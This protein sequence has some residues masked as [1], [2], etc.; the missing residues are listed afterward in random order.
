M[1]PVTAADNHVIQALERMWSKIREQDS[2]IP[3]VIFDLTP[4]ASSSCVS[5]GWD[6][7]TPVVEVNLRPGG[8]NST[9]AELLEF[10]LHQAAHSIAGPVNPKSSEGR[11][12][13]TTYR[14]AAEAIGLVTV[15][16][17]TGYGAT[18]LA[19]GTRT[20]YRSEISA[21]GRALAK[22]EPT[23]QVKTGRSSRNGVVLVCSCGPEPRKIRIRGNPEKIDITGIRCE[24]CQSPFT[25]S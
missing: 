16:D 6:Q 21:L 24:I 25:P 3:A 13:G 8:R 10:L 23:E 18:S 14:V 19:A 22:W 17:A 2:R 15:R 4:G 1:R 12:H 5:V 11:W 7:P 20:R 9:A